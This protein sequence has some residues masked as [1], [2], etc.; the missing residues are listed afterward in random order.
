M[1]VGELDQVENSTVLEP[2]LERLL[3]MLLRPGI[4]IL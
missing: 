4:L 3:K 2:I 1:V